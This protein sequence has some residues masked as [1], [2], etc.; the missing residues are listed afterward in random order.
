M[1]TKSSFVV[2]RDRELNVFLDYVQF[3]TV[4]SEFTQK[5]SKQNEESDAD[6]TSDLEKHQQELL[7][8][9]RFTTNLLFLRVYSDR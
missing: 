6:D 7:E 1:Q 2:G 3:G 5:C 4:T 8:G 9:M